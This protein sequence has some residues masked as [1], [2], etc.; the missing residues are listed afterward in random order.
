MAP[1]AEGG[2][3]LK[4]GDRA[5][6]FEL[7]DD[8]GATVR[9]SDLR[10]SRVVVYF[11]PADDTP[12]CTRQACSLR[13]AHGEFEGAGA[14]VLGVSPDDVD[15]HQRFREKFGLPFSLLA[16]TDHAVAEAYGVWVEKNNDGKRS[17]GIK[18]S[19]FVIGED[20]TVLDAAYGVKPE[21]TSPRAL[22]ALAVES[23]S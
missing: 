12:G 23:P 21:D 8:G 17:L 20:G 16:D 22:A 19:S 5:P 1:R 13:D 7:L 18:R 6:D 14:R 4:A 11:Y 10:G 9:L 3:V 2:A 15:S